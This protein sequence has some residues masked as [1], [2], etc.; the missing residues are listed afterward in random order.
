MKGGQ[1]CGRYL[2]SNNVQ[3][4][5]WG[6][7]GGDGGVGCPVPTPTPP[8]PSSLPPT[9]FGSLGG[10]PGCHAR[11]GGHSTRSHTACL[12]RSASWGEA[13]P[14]VQLLRSAGPGTAGRG[15]GGSTV[16]R[17]SGGRGGA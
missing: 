9:C 6:G 13:K 11:G 5:G 7:G 8:A 12:S 10:V 17:Y 15:V 2:I 1:C 14:T 16:L 3:T 4:Q